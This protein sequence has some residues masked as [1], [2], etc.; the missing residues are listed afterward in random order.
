MST[1][2]QSF[3]QKSQL[4]KGRPSGLSIFLLHCTT[5]GGA[6]LFCPGTHNTSCFPPSL[7]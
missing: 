5:S 2:R 1:I 4:G 7:A 6:Y 3:G